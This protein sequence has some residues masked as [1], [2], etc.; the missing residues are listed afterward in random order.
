MEKKAGKIYGKL[1]LDLILLVL[2]SLMYQKRVIS[3]EFHETGGA[4]PRC[5][6]CVAQSAE[7]AMDSCGDRWD[8]PP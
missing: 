1:F 6:V 7:L 4:N 5:P 3:M 2:L 8:F